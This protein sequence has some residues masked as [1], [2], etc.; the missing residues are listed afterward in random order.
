MTAKNRPDAR[1]TSNSGML[2]IILSNALTIVMAAVMPWA[3]VHLLWPFF[4]QSVIIGVFWYQ[5]IRSLETFCTDYVMINNR[6][7]DSTPATRDWIARFFAWHYGAFHMAY[8]IALA[9]LTT[10]SYRRHQQP[11]PEDSTWQLIG[12]ISPVDL[13]FL[14]VISFS[15]FFSHR[16]AFAEQVAADRERKP[17]IGR[18]M[19]LPYARILPMHMAL[20]LGPFIGQAG[21]TWLFATLKAIADTLMHK[22]EDRWMDRRSER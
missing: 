20:A 10:T 19:I 13:I 2:A 14:M 16:L 15:F 17:D 5:R 21:M 7:V 1:M 9:I 3:L 4:I 6:S 18:L 12:V 11:L 22:L 8:F